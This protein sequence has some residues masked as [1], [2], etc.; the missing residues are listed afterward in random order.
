MRKGHVL[1]QL[2][3]CLLLVGVLLVSCGET[4][5]PIVPPTVETPPAEEIPETPEIS[6]PPKSEEPTNPSPTGDP[7]LD[8][9]L[10]VPGQG[11]FVS[12]DT[13]AFENI[14]G[15][16][17]TVDTFRRYPNERYNNPNVA[18][19]IMLAQ[20]INYKQAH[21]EA[22]VYASVT[23]FHLSVVASACIDRTAEDFGLMKSLYDCDYDDAGY[24]RIVYLILYAA[25][26]GIH[27]TAI[28]QIDGSAVVADTN[29]TVRP[30]LSFVDYFT[31]QLDLDS[32]IAG[33]KIGD[34]LNFK[35]AKWTSYGDKSAS[36]MMHVKSCTVSNYIDYEGVEHGPAVWVGSTNIDGIN[37]YGYNGNNSYQTGAVLANH[38]EIRQVVYNYTLLMARYC[39]Q[40]QIG[41]FRDIIRQMNTEQIALI[42]AGEGDTIPVEERIVYL[43][44]ASDTVFEFYFTPLGGSV[45]TWDTTYNPYSKYI[46]KLMPS[47]SGAGDITLSWNNVKY[48][49]N[50]EFAYT[51]ANVINNAFMQSGKLT[52]KL[53]LHLP[54]LDTSI[55]SGLVEGENI[56]KKVVNLNETYAFHNKDFQLS[57]IENGT[58]YYVTVLNTLNFHQGAASYQTNYFFVIKETEATGNYVYVSV[59]NHTSLGV[60]TKADLVE[61]KREE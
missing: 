21:P 13:V 5:A 14:N 47:V 37:V 61:P 22:E 9:Y 11:N 39:E 30:D 46:S 24:V 29:G 43:G 56:G 38:E 57:Y 35:E 3:A 48:I 41:E 53:Y 55:M 31:A 52:N 34:F 51:L 27:I 26:I 19:A 12:R 50:F 6:D 40:E 28:G 7:T 4:P 42:E 44:T 8:T 23:S 10:N 17:V 16:T 45:G 36:D 25:R 49:M 32:D 60:I 15:K 20:C 59:G 58:R 18:Q 33:K 54:G 2:L 1:I